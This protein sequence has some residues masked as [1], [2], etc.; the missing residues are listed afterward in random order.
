M[1]SR[2]PVK[3]TDRPKTRIRRTR[4]IVEEPEAVV[5][6]QH[7]GTKWFGVN[8][9]FVIGGVIFLLLILFLPIFSAT[10]MVEKT[11]TVMVPVQKERQ[12]E[13]TVDES[14]KVY[15]GY[16]Q[17][18]GSSVARTGY[19][20][21]YDYWGDPYYVPY[22]YYDEAAGRTVTIDAVDEIVEY[23]QARGPNDTWVITLISYDGTQVVHRDIT[24]IDLT[25]TG[26]AT[27]KATKTVFT[28]YTEMEP[29][30]VTKE[31]A[32]KVRVSLINLIFGNY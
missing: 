28:P 5:K 11:E 20:I 31:V 7:G 2:R 26:K 29:Q 8:P 30:E 6:T 14:I 4:R 3:G 1:A 24:N 15:Q 16:L 27:V 32:A 9:W 13:V 12:E 25:K 17:E 21:A 19:Y 22:T 10:K 23:Q 18:Q